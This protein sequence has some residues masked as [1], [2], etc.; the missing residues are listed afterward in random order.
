M[1]EVVMALL[2]RR[3]VF[4]VPSRRSRAG[5]VVAVLSATFIIMPPLVP[6]RA[7]DSAKKEAYT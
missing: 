2:F 7:G 4:F 5:I 3:A 6:C 1:D